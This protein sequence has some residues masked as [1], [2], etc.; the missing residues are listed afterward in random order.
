MKQQGHT[1]TAGKVSG[2]IRITAGTVSKKWKVGL[3][4]CV[5]KVREEPRVEYSSEN[6]P[7]GRR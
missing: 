7:F 6:I 1:D 4:L 2:I 3:G 5:I